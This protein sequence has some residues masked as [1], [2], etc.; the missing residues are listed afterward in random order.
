MF[1]IT[2]KKLLLDVK[3]KK[4]YQVQKAPKNLMIMNAG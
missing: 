1:Y 2:V 4:V 3:T